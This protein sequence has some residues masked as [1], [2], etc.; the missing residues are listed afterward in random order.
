MGWSWRSINR[1]SHTLAI[2]SICFLHFS[3]IGKT[4]F[5]QATLFCDSSYSFQ[6]SNIKIFCRTSLRN[7][8]DYK[9]ETWYTCGQWM[10]VS[11]ILESSASAVY[12]SLYF[13][14]MILQYIYMYLSLSLTKSIVCTFCFKL[15]KQDK[16]QN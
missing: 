1:R 6:F 2:L 5:R 16:A 8:E 9:V 10:D 7:C 11:C 15:E 3:F 13:L 4:N 14:N 12:S